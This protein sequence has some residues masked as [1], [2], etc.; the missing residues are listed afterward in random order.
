MYDVNY[1]SIL[2]HIIIKQFLFDEINK[3]SPIKETFF[4][5]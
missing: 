4:F 1:D 5:L 3:T 2:L